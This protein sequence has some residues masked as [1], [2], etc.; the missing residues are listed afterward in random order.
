MIDL[1]TEFIEQITEEKLQGKNYFPRSITA[2]F[3]L[4]I[5]QGSTSHEHC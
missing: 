3:R 5:F 2:G 4:L 1:S